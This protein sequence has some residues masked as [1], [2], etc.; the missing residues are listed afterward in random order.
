[1]KRLVL[2]SLLLGLA[3][4]NDPPKPSAD[5]IEQRKQETMLSEATSQVDLPSI[6]NFQEKRNLKLV[7][8]L[9][10]RKVPTYAYLFNPYQGCFVF[11]G[12]S[13]GYPVPYATQYTNPQK[14]I[15][16]HAFHEA[17]VPIANAD[18]N[19]LFKPT[20][21]DGT[22]V[23]MVNPT[24]KALEPQYIEDRVED[25]TFRVPYECKN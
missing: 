24:T 18:P 12:A 22:W 25:F 5:Q 14:M 16:N 23:M 21:A 10:D 20:T 15:S 4:C 7:E 19:G 2:L 3:A 9:A 8:E 6:T 1:M 11:L 17:N 13:Y